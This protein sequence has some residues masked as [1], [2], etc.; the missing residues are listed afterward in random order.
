MGVFRIPA[1]KKSFMAK[2]VLI[3]IK[4]YLPGKQVV[5]A[6]GVMDI[7]VCHVLEGL[8]EWLFAGFAE[9]KVFESI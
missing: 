1:G 7:V 6:I 5:I 4:Y 3:G 9:Y 2:D 8:P